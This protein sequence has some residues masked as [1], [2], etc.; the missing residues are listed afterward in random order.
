[1]RARGFAH[2]R[3]STAISRG[4]VG[5]APSPRARTSAAMRSA[6]SAASAAAV[7]HRTTRTGS[8]TS[9]LVVSVLSVRP[10][11]PATDAAA[12]ATIV[13]LER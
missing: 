13:R 12:A 4:G 6:T 3:Q 2:L 1:M 9:F 11:I 5:A 7:A 8:P 10:R